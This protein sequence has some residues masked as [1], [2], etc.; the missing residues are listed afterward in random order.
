[1]RQLT[2]LIKRYFGFSRSETNGFLVLIPLM[3]LIMISEPVYRHFSRSS[4]KKISI[5]PL[6]SADTQP[7]SDK[8]P[9][10][11][12]SRSTN[13]T[14]FK[15]DPNSL[16][17]DSLKLLGFDEKMA[18]R[19]VNYRDKGGRFRQPDD[20]LKLYGIRHEFF[21][22]LKPWIS[23]H[24]TRNV[25][26]NQEQKRTASPPA[27][28]DIN[29]VDSLTLQSVRGI[30]P[31]LSV[32]IMRYRESLGGFISTGQLH[33]V[34]GLDSAVAAELKKRCF[35]GEDFTPTKLNLN[36]ADERQLSS[37]PYLTK[38]EAQIIVMYR[39]Q[40]GNFNSVDDLKQIRGLKETTIEKIWP[41]LNVD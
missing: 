6:H 1:M 37:H 16:G 3:G 34:Y 9:V 30:G 10:A 20:L 28:F 21:D 40:H 23:I 17:L 4:P 11:N 2:Q 24:E 27:S 13:V 18:R 33:Q 5:V 19:L 26:L 12:Q 39:M 29:L 32:R 36:K 41:Y 7:T 31:V 22:L 15:F 35:I 8:D 14:L 38:K 25:E